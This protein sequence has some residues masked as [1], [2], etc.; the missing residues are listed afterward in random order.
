MPL[1]KTNLY[2]RTT[3]SYWFDSEISKQSKGI[4]VSYLFRDYIQFTKK[5]QVVEA[6]PLSISIPLLWVV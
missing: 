2:V 6:Y 1:W 5:G 4:Y 3:R